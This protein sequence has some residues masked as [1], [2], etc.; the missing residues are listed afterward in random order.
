MWPHIPWEGG[1]AGD[2]ATAAVTFG[3]PP[4]PSN[5]Y[6]AYVASATVAATFTAVLLAQEWVE[7]A[8][9]LHPADSLYVGLWVA[10]SVFC[11]LVARPFS[12]MML[13]SLVTVL[14]CSAV[15][16]AEGGGWTLDIDPSVRC[17]EGD[18]TADGV[19]AI[20]ALVAWVPMTVRFVRAHS[21]V[22]NIEATWNV[23]DWSAD[24]VSRPARRH[25]LSFSGDSVWHHLA[26]TLLKG[27]VVASVVLQTTRP[28]VASAIGLA[29]AAIVT[30]VGFV[31]PPFFRRDELVNAAN[32][33]ANLAITWVFVCALLASTGM[34]GDAELW[35]YLAIGAPIAFVVGV[36]AARWIPWDAPAQLTWQGQVEV[37]ELMVADVEAGTPRRFH[38]DS[39]FGQVAGGAMAAMAAKRA[40]SSRKKGLM[41]S[42]RVTPVS[43]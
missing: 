25:P 6:A 31:K 14:D 24:S 26:A 19:L 4:S 12:A 9:F 23:F 32:C 37:D 13:L 18:H 38:K 27:G 15:P 28:V 1:A 8:I 29:F 39:K 42:A 35:T 22:E 16:E 36:V 33:G 21:R 5:W 30:I 41:A 10:L 2:F 3:V 34:E 40:L 17:W 20:V 43:E 7:M 11:R